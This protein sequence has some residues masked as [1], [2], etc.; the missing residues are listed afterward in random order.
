MSLKENRDGLI[1]QHGVAD[2]RNQREKIEKIQTRRQKEVTAEL[3]QLQRK[4]TF[5]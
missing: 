2:R 3:E 1:K 5:R 4:G